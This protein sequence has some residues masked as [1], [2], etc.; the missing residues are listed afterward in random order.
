MLVDC[1]RGVFVHNSYTKTN[2]KSCVFTIF[3]TV[4]ALIS[5]MHKY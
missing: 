3:S 1:K 4:F 5:L 2:R